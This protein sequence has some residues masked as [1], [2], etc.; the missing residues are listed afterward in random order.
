[1]ILFLNTYIPSY[2][3]E[4][5]GVEL[6]AAGSIAV[7][8]PL[9]GIVSR[10]SSDWLSDRFG[11]RRR[12]V[13]GLAFLLT[14]P[15]FL[16]ATRVDSLLGFAVLLSLIGFTRQFGVG[17]YYASVH[18]FAADRSSRT[19]LAVLAV[20]SALGMLLAPVVGSWLIETLSWIAGFW[21]G[22]GLAATG[23]ICLLAIPEY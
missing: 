8:V 22:A 20:A 21:F 10:P 18:E 23:L 2:A 16:A 15:L 5:L 19:S 13:L 14:V 4:I 7:L 9:A 6:V 11:S 17:V 12:P 3:I 1:M